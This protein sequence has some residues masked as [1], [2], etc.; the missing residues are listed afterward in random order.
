MKVT[1]S[2]HVDIDSDL[3]V[4]RESSTLS[5]SPVAL[6]TGEEGYICDRADQVVESKYYHLPLVYCPYIPSSVQNTPERTSLRS[7]PLV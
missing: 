1:T 7:R 6:I 4:T 2:D 5:A 3:Q